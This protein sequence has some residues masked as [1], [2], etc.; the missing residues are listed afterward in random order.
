MDKH[1]ANLQHFGQSVVV[2]I[3]RFPTDTDSEIDEIRKHCTQ[4]GIPFAV[5]TAYSEGG[6][7][8]EALAQIV[9][10]TIEQHPSAPLQYI[11]EPT[12]AIQ[13]KVD[14]IARQIYGASMV[15]YQGNALKK[16]RQ[17][18]ELGYSHFPVCI[19]K[20]QYSFSDNPTAYGAPKGFTLKVQDVVVN[21]GAEMIV[22]I[23]GD[24][25]R[26]PGLPK[27]PSALNIDIVNGQ[28]EGLS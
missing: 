5:N 28:I 12:D 25:M 9:V 17:I 2:C 11:Y 4:L 16:I 1:I 10:E 27:V 22:V 15:E 23:M 19:A 20:T 6:A 24:M 18:E 26:M 3:N 14:K 8:A 7:G 21:A 13:T